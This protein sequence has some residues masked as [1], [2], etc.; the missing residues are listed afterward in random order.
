MKKIWMLIG[1]LMILQATLAMGQIDSQWRGPNRDGTYPNEKLLKSWP[2]DGPKL[3]WS[4]EVLGIGYS[5]PSVTA[6]RVYITG[7]EGSTGMLYALDMKGKLLWKSEYGAEY[8]DAQPGSRTTPAVVGDRIY[9]ISGKGRVVCF[10]TQ[11]KTVWA[12]DGEKEFGARDIRWGI[13][14]SPLVDGDRVFFTPGGSNAAVAALDRHTGKTIWKTKTNG[15][16]SAYCSPY[17]VRHGSRRLLL[18]MTQK[19][20]IGIDADTGD[21]LWDYEHVT[22]YDINPNTPFYQDGFMY[23]TSGYGTGGQMFKISKDGGSIEQVWSQ[24]T[25]DSQMGSFI[26][27]DGTIYGSGHNNRGWHGLNWKTGEV[28]FSDR[29]LGSKGN[30]IFSDGMF[31]CYS[32]KGDVGLVKPSPDKFEVVSS[33]KVKMGSNE[34]WAHLVIKNGR[35][36]VRHG[37]ALMVYDISR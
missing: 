5:S 34:H 7:M 25:L 33:F 10:D 31:Y 29:V 4:T 22:E 16:Q 37:E 24:K 35:L 27:L 30:I 23:V 2:K 36:Y 12:V 19:S 32:E 26:V 18:T 20:V 14:E 8:D 11:G 1:L 15:D 17:I 28:Q 6:D 3:I 21:F 13:T 9:V